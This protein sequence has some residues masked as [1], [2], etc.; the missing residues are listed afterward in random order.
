MPYTTFDATVAGVTKK[1]IDVSG[2]QATVILEES[3]DEQGKL[4]MNL[5]SA[6]AGATFGDKLAATTLASG[7]TADVVYAR[8][9]VTLAT[10]DALKTKVALKEDDAQA[11][12]LVD[13]EDRVTTLETP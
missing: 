11:D 13:L 4:D 5:V 2:D 8:L 6:S 10:L 7:K 9:L 3:L 1:A 12:K